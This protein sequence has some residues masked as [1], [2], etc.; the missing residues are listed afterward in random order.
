MGLGTLSVVHPFL[1]PLDSSGLFG[2]GF[3]LSFLLC[4]AIGIA[5]IVFLFVQ[6]RMAAE[7]R[8]AG[9]AGFA[10]A[11]EWRYAPNDP[12]LVTRFA[13]HPFG[14]GSQRSAANV[15][16]GAHEGRPFAAFDYHYRTG[17]GDDSASHTVGVVA[18][19][20]GVPLPALTV[21]EQGAIGRFFGKLAGTDLEIGRPDF[22]AAFRV[23]CSQVEFARD[24]L[25]PVMCDL[26]MT[27]PHMAFRFDRDSMLI[28]S[29]GQQAPQTIDA[30]LLSMSLI[31]GQVPGHVWERLGKQA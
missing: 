15:V 23:N 29:T 20:C 9:M 30:K 1:L 18:V 4:P 28:V 14:V 27:M 11:R 24:F 5:L 31:L 16:F 6:A 21:A 13:G 22:D 8:K 17:S 3:G 25:H 19:S 7:A 26:L 12:S 10:A 2:I